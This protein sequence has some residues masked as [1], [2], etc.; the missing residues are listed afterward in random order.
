V[1]VSPE[2]VEAILAKLPEKAPRGGYL[3]RA[4]LVF[5]YETGL[6][7]G[8]IGA[9]KHPEHFARG[10]DH[11][12]VEA[13]DDKGR[14]ERKVPLSEP[15]RQALEQAVDVLD[16]KPGLLFGPHPC[17]YQAK[18][19]AA[20]VLPPDRA[21][22]FAPYDLRHARATHLL[23][24][25]SNVPGVQHLLGHKHLATTSRYL[26][27]SERAARQVLDLVRGN[28]WGNGTPE[29]LA[30][31]TP[32]HQSS[33]FDASCTRE[34]SNLHTSRYRN[35]NRHRARRK[36]QEASI[37]VVSLQEGARRSTKAHPIRSGGTAG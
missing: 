5:A 35:L 19:A 14:F 4:R 20:K 26:R 24:E 23:E 17:L 33:V 15:A 27:P 22:L 31:V 10:Q 34:D 21:K 11:V 6:R 8:T 7:P 1:E 32:D 25:T 18:Q 9:L 12:V 30:E 28:K 29:A 16:G 2:E 3:V 37:S 13:Q 36:L